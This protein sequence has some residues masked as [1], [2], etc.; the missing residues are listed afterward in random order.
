MLGPEKFG[1]RQRGL[2][3]IFVHIIVAV[4]DIQ[5][6]RLKKA[7]RL[8]TRCLLDQEFPPFLARI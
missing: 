5:P 4:R 7:N 3:L 6:V 2:K 8:E 1:R